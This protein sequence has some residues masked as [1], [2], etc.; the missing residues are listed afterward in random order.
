MQQPQDHPFFTFCFF[1]SGRGRLTVDGR[2][3]LVPAHTVS[4]IPPHCKHQLAADSG[5]ACGLQVLQFESEW[6]V[7]GAEPATLASLERLTKAAIEPIPLRGAASRQIT[8]QLVAASQASARRDALTCHRIVT[9]LC[10]RLAQLV[11]NT[12]APAL[13]EHR[14]GRPA[15]SLTTQGRPELD[16]VLQ[17]IENNLSKPISR[18][19]LARQAAFAPS[20]FS[21]LFRE[22]TGT[23]IPEYINI[24][25]VYR[26]KELLRQPETRVSSVCYAVGFRDLSNFNRVF[27]RVVGCTP[28]EFRE[29]ELNTNHP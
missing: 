14:S 3:R 9:D 13:V 26:A 20:Y 29:S 18:Q 2:A 8:A 6:F 27:K 21:A 19:E 5:W 4:L 11:A 16:R 10:Y 7:E 1:Q 15:T 12:P 22:A 23:T 24:R 28:R 17:F 25:R